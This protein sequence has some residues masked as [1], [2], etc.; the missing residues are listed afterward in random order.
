MKTMIEIR[1]VKSKKEQRNFLNFPL[2]LYRDNPCFVPPLY[3]DEKKM[4]RKDFVYL[5]TC[6]HVFFNAYENGK[7]VGRISGILQKASNEKTGE[8]RIRF[9]RFDAVNNQAVADALFAALEAWGREKGMDTVCG[10]LGYSDLEREG[11]LIEGFDQL[12]TFEEQYNAD[13][14]QTLIEGCGYGKEVDWVESKIYLPEEDDGSLKKMAKFILDRYHLHYGTAKNVRQFIDIY[15]DRFFA[16][17]DECYKDIYGT[18]PF[19]EG[20]KK[21]TIDN[22]LLI[23]DLKHVGVVLDEADNLVCLGI[24]F[25]SIAKAV[26]PSRGHLTPAALVRLLNAIKHPE[27]LDLGLVAVDPRYVNKGVA[28]AVS[29]ELLRM[30]KLDGIQYAETNLNLEDN[31]SIQNMWKRFRRVQHKRRRSY[32]K[33]LEEHT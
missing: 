30:L 3:M 11:L 1:E 18:V 32:I 24:C 9:T 4:F 7:Q 23:M 22:F 31:Y 27:V 25:P 14:Y 10:P 28:A 26:Q 16:L 29:A 20:M 33:K 5:D 6:E 19:T 12:S 17:L 13:Y 2:K 21:M 8:K 15:G